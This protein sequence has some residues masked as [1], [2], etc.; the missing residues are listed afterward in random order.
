M[1]G[2]F[3][4]LVYSKRKNYFPEIHIVNKDFLHKYRKLRLNCND[5]RLFQFFFKAFKLFKLNLNDVQANKKVLVKKLPFC[6]KLRRKCFAANLCLM[7]NSCGKEHK[8]HI[9]RILKM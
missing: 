3:S 2:A 6:C 4:I 5:L 9:L 7:W 1:Q 8:L